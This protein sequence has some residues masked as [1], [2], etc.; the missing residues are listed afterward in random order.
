MN[1][2]MSCDQA[3]AL[4]NWLQDGDLEYW[5]TPLASIA[6]QLKSHYKY[7][8]DHNFCDGSKYRVMS[9][10]VLNG[11][12]PD[13]EE[14]LVAYKCFICGEQGTSFGTPHHVR[15]TNKMNDLVYNPHKVLVER[16]KEWECAHHEAWRAGYVR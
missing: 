16:D 1:L 5:E 8:C 3:D 14:A 11:K 15:V 6:D 7:G 4:F 12:H 9:M 13:D 10:Q 2:R